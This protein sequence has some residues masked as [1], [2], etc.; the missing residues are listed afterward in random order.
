M[1]DLNEAG[2]VKIVSTTTL[3]LYEKRYG[4]LAEDL[5]KQSNKILMKTQEITNNPE[6]IRRLG[7]IAINTAIE[8]DIYGNVNSTHLNGS[9]IMNGIGG[10]G[11]FTRNARI[12]IFVTQSIAKD[13]K[14]STIVPFASH[15]DHP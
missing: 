8:V 12:S 5:K 4:T 6:V 2:I 1:F 13:G 14:I 3:A 9:H 10:S 15:I 11:D 7:V